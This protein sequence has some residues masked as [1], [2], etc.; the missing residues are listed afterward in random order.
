VGQSIEVMDRAVVGEIAIFGIDRGLTGMDG[1]G[2]DSAEEAGAG[3]GPPALLAERLFGAVD[4]VE[5]VFVSAND[6]LVQRTDGWSDDALDAASSV[7]A[8]LFRH[9]PQ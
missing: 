3:L 6:V 9:Y 5:R 4:R 8:D 7:I 2:F 1:Y